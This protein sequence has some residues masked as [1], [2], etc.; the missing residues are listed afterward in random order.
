ME[1]KKGILVLKNKLNDISFKVVMCDGR[2]CELSG[3]FYKFYMSLASDSQLLINNYFNG[4]RKNIKEVLSL[5][6]VYCKFI[7]VTIDC[8][9]YPILYEELT[10]ADGNK[11][12]K[13]YITDR[14]F[15]IHTKFAVS[16]IKVT[17][18]KEIKNMFQGKEDSKLYRIVGIDKKRYYVFSDLKHR[19]YYTNDLGKQVKYDLFKTYSE[20]CEGEHLIDK[21]EKVNVKEFTVSLPLSFVHN[22]ANRVEVA[23]IEKGYA[24]EDERSRYVSKDQFAYGIRRKVK[25]LFTFNNLK[26][27][28]YQ[29]SGMKTS[30]LTSLIN[31]IEGLLNRIKDINETLYNEAN[32][33]YQTIIS[34]EP[35]IQTN[36]YGEL[37][38]FY[39]SLKETIN[40]SIDGEEANEFLV[41]YI[42]I[43]ID[44]MANEIYSN[45]DHPYV[46]DLHTRFIMNE[47]KYGISNVQKINTKFNYLYFFYL[48][49]NRDNY[50]SKEIGNSYIGTCV[51]GIFNIIEGLT[52]ANII[53]CSIDI[54][55]YN[56]SLSLDDLLTIIKN[57][58][59]YDISIAKQ[60]IK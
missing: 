34:S 60:L 22:N 13:E 35:N 36:V 24:N 59:L 58:E 38:D 53:G 2:V 10:D 9:G 15:P 54:T 20:S 25:K 45:I 4:D 47:D 52:R 21:I 48:Y 3:D 32:K 23:L 42:N 37:E 12:G 17:K 55:N 50:N 57:I 27:I 41:G 8:K 31:E 28:E 14:L 56:S 44:N 19:K 1:L 7:N 30:N 18:P 16:D 11:Y 6:D 51:Q 46:T 5:L 26:E 39:N 40:L 29:S 43:L 49:N 33:R